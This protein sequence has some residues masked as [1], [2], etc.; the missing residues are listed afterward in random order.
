MEKIPNPN[1]SQLCVVT[2]SLK[3]II[4]SEV[5]T[6]ITPIFMI[7]KISEELNNLLFSD[8]I[9]YSRVI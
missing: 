6:I 7:G 9:K 5:Q 1:P 2:L 8:F 4:E 3:M